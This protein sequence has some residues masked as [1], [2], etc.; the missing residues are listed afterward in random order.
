MV[1]LFDPFRR[2]LT[3]YS[4]SSKVKKNFVMTKKRKVIPDIPEYEKTTEEAEKRLLAYV[5]YVQSLSPRIMIVRPI[6]DAS[7]NLD[8]FQDQVKISLKYSSD[9]E[10]IVIDA[11]PDEK[12]IAFIVFIDSSVTGEKKEHLFWDIH[13]FCYGDFAFECCRNN[14]EQDEF[15]DEDGVMKYF[16]SESLELDQMVWKRSVSKIKRTLDDIQKKVPSLP[17]ET[18]PV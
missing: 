2:G 8:D 12:D 1:F 15:P 6:L 9:P 4:Y 7:F 3:K 14:F 18:P 5:D 17:E 16:F 13:V 10:E 11:W